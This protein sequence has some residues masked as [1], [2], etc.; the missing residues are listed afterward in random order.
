M[1]PKDAVRIEE[2]LN[3]FPYDYPPPTG[4]DPFSVRVE[5]AGCP[6]NAEHRLVRIGLKGRPIDAGQAAAEQPRLPDRRLRLDAATPTSCR[7]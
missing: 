5:V 6:W 1:P 4:D 2:L 3:Y 7:S